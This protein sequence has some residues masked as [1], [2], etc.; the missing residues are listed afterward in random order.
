[1]YY[2]SKSLREDGAKE[3]AIGGRTAAGAFVDGGGLVRPGGSFAGKSYDF[4]QPGW[5]YDERFN[6]Q[7]FIWNDPE[8]SRG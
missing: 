7:P 1:M 5:T 2:V 4:W 3:I 6:G 8:P